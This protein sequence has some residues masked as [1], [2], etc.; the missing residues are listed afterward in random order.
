[1]AG[2]E[3]TK[4]APDNIEPD[5]WLDRTGA[6]LDCDEKL[7]VLRENIDEIHDTVRAALEDAVLMEVDEGQF[8]DTL[9]RLVDA[10][11]SPYQKK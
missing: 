2:E 7:M 6:A 5:R 1:M 4:T 11:E 9:K 8:R 3:K 10:L